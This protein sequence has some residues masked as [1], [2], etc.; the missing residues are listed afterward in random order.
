MHIFRDFCVGN[1]GV[2][3]GGVYV[4]VSQHLR[5]GFYRHAIRKSHG[6]CECMAALM[7]GDVAFNATQT[8]HLAQLFVGSGIV[9]QVE[10]CRFIC[11]VV[12]P[13]DTLGDIQQLNSDRDGCLLSFWRKYEA[14]LA[15][16]GGKNARC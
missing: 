7:I 13:D 3:L 12:L 11:A 8:H 6:C 14:H 1:S 16:V 15:V 4:C 2:D 9:W 10:Q 5:Y